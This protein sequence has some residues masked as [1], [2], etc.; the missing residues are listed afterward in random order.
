MDALLRHA[1]KGWKGPQ[2]A[3]PL[4][5]DMIDAAILMNISSMNQSPV[6]CHLIHV[7]MTAKKAADVMKPMPGMVEVWWAAADAIDQVIASGDIQ[8]EVQKS[9]LELKNVPELMTITDFQKRKRS[10][11]ASAVCD[12]TGLHWFK[13]L[14][15]NLSL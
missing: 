1:G 2:S 13:I 15:M 9:V 12:R 3:I 4:F 11:D 14:N 5:E 10:N 8:W 7:T 6:E